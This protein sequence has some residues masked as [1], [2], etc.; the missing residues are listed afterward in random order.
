ML[1][2]PL[3]S[4]AAAAAAVVS[5]WVLRGSGE[6]HLL[7]VAGGRTAKPAAGRLLPVT[8]W[9]GEGATVERSD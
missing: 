8:N 1:S 6:P 7:P 2:T 5:P 4:H 9:C 3:L